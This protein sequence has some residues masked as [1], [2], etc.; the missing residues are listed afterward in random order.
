MLDNTYPIEQLDRNNRDCDFHLWMEIPL[1]LQEKIH[2]MRLNANWRDQG[3]GNRKGEVFITT[4]SIT[5]FRQD[6]IVVKSGIAEHRSRQLYL[7]FKPQPG[8]K[9]YLM[10][11]VGGGGGHSLHVSD[12]NLTFMIHGAGV[13]R[14]YRSCCGNEGGLQIALLEAAASSIENALNNGRD[15]DRYLESALRPFDLRGEVNRETINSLRD[16]ARLLL[17]RE[18]KDRIHKLEEERS[19]DSDSDY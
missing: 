10:Y 7:E 1:L 6:D 19:L 15:P 9:Y 18:E 12:V 11:K 13:A 8:K 16:M 3:W 14:M 17:E 5:P 4:T 2:S